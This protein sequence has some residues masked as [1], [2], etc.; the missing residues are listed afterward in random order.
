MRKLT[1]LILVTLFAA[2]AG[3]AERRP[4]GHYLSDL[5]SQ[6]VL[7]QGAPSARG[8]LLGVQPELYAPDYQ[9]VERLRLKLAAY[10]EKARSEGLLGPRTVVVFPEHIGTWL[11]AA[12]EKPEVYQTEHLAEA[13]EWM[14]ASNPLKLARG[15]LGARRVRGGLLSSFMACFRAARS[16][17]SSSVPRRA[18]P[19]EVA[20]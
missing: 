6:V 18:S 12:G 16:T 5:R 20:A 8:N 19:P 7:N 14:A 11:V 3:W 15:W 10:L 2:Y 17:G 4:V 9:N 13:M 1:F